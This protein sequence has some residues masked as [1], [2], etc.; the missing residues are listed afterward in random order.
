[1]SEMNCVQRWRQQQCE[2][3]KDALDYLAPQGAEA[4]H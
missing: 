2:A 1:M 3:G 4:L